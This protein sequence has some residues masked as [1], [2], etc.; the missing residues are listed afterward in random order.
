[1]REGLLARVSAAVGVTPVLASGFGLCVIEAQCPGW[2]GIATVRSG[3]ARPKCGHSF[4]HQDAG[5]TFRVAEAPE[6]GII[7]LNEGIHLCCSCAFRPHEGFGSRKW[8]STGGSRRPASRLN[9][10]I[11]G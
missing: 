1:M 9:V 7:G 5:R 3:T 11:H 4:G 2:A 6:Y 8:L 10:G